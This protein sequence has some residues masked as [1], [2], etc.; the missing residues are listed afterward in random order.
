MAAGQE[1]AALKDKLYRPTT[2]LQKLDLTIFNGQ[3]T[4]RSDGTA[5]KFTGDDNYAQVAQAMQEV[6]HLSMEKLGL[7]KSL[8]GQSAQSPGSTVFV[9]SGIEHAATVCVLIQG[10]GAVRFV[11]CS[12]HILRIVV[13]LCVHR[14]GLWARSVAIND[15]LSKGDMNIDIQNCL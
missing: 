11:A 1:A 12:W 8:I 15:N 5:F 6:V 14:P 10:L 13:H 4:Q 3:I 2:R 9:S 7:E